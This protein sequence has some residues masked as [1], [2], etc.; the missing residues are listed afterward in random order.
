MLVIDDVDELAEKCSGISKSMAECLSLA[1]E[2]GCGIVATVQ[3]MKTKGFDE[4]TKFF[5]TTT[6]GILVGNPGS[7]SIFPTV[8]AR[9]LPTMG[10]GMLYYNGDFEKVLLPKYES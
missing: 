1:A 4:V 5:K 9:N 2:T 7:T 3:S 10:E 6:N 8:A